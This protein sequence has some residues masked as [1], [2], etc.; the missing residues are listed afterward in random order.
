MSFWNAI[1]AQPQKQKTNYVIAKDVVTLLDKEKHIGIDQTWKTLRFIGPIFGLQTINVPLIK[2]GKF[3][4]KEATGKLISIPKTSL[5]YDYMTNQLDESKCPYL[6]HL[7]LS[8]PALLQA[9]IDYIETSTMKDKQLVLDHLK[10]KG[11]AATYMDKTCR[12]IIKSSRE[13]DDIISNVSRRGTKE[14]YSNV[15]LYPLIF[16]AQTQNMFLN[17]QTRSESENTPVDFLY[18]TK[19]YGEK[20]FLK[21]ANSLS[22]TPCKVIKLTANQLEKFN[23]DVVQLN[24]TDQPDGSRVVHD[25]EHPLYGCKINVRL[26]PTPM[27]NFLTGKSMYSYVFNKG[28]K[29]PLSEN[30]KQLLIHDLTKLQSNESYNEAVEFLNSQ[31]YINTPLNIVSGQNN[32][33]PPNNIVYGNN[34]GN[35]FSNQIASIASVIA[36]TN[37]HQPVM[38]QPAPLQPTPI[39]PVKMQQPATI[40][41]DK[42]FT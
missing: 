3:F 5:G 24:T 18:Y 42:M 16:D 35:D 26:E 27:K 32:S 41:F 39:E 22:Q 28:D 40:D 33:T 2:A 13:L 25:V 38:Q 4:R 30:E 36:P 1:Q 7:K 8:N 10:Y 14:F 19:A 34:V 23:K 37:I 11:L 12:D 20:V 21:D 17:K 9:V 6:E 31:G 29:S 15:I